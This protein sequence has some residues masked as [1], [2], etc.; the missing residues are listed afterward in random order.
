[1]SFM[2]ISAQPHIKILIH[3]SVCR[4]LEPVVCGDDTAE[5]SLLLYTI[6]RLKVGSWTA[7]FPNQP[8]PASDVLC[9]RA[10]DYIAADSVIINL[11]AH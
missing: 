4:T 11:Y 10:I 6:G 8:V 5:N 7:N 1:M 3:T 2:I 9:A